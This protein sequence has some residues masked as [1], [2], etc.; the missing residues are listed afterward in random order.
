M[1]I[2]HPFVGSPQQYAEHIADPNH[3]RLQYCPQ[4]LLAPV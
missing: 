4:C 1:Q 3:D 2:L